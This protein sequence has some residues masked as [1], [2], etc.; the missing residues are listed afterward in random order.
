MSLSDHEKLQFER[1]TSD[2][3]IEDPQ[4]A[5]EYRKLKKDSG[6]AVVSVAAM[7]A[8]IRFCYL[9]GL[10]A[11]IFGFMT[12]NPG[13]MGFALLLFITATVMRAVSPGGLFGQPRKRAERR[14]FMDWIADK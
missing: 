11:F 3:S 1:L 12:I 8:T 6:D 5:K 14:S 13:S 4:I 7:R 9:T 2:F 10:V